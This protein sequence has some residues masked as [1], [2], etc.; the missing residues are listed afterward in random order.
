MEKEVKKPAYSVKKLA[1]LTGVSVRTLHLYDQ[2]GLLKPSVRTEAGYRLYGETELLRMQQILFYKE[3]DF[4]LQEIG[5]ILNDPDFD[6]VQALESHREALKSRKNRLTKLLAT[7][8]NTITKIKNSMELTLEELYDGFPKGKAKEWRDEVTHKY[9]ADA[10][11]RS[12]RYLGK[13][14]KEGFARLKEDNLKI[15]NQLLQLVEEDPTSDAVQELIARHY[16]VIRKFWGTHGEADNQ[17]E[18]YAG[19]GELYV[20]D[21]RYTTHDGKSNPEFALFMRRAMKHFAKRLSD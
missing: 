11:A 1:D 16:E 15:T 12:E 17:A 9:G 14:G 19:L 10:I 18:A 2:I 5:V 8:D 3:L 21:E 4:S 6:L 20:A 13:L 7:I